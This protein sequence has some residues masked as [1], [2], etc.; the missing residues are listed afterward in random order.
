[1]SQA[2]LVCRRADDTGREPNKSHYRRWIG[3][4]KSRKY[5]LLSQIL[6]PPCGQRN[7]SRQG[8]VSA[9]LAPILTNAL[10][11]SL[12]A[13]DLVEASAMELRGA[14]I[15]P[16][17]FANGNTHNKQLRAAESMDKSKVGT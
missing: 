10:R 1:M 7:I 8:A 11:N 9:D 12:H 13:R 3:C 5:R 14:C 17:L 6:A 2:A 16:K 15:R 4:G